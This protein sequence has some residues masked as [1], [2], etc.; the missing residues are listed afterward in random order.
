[1][2]DEQV[3]EVSDE[4]SR[5]PGREGVTNSART[6]WPLKRKNQ[7]KAVL[8]KFINIFIF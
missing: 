6:R 4:S 7:E 3:S 1:L 2:W 8:M 5:E